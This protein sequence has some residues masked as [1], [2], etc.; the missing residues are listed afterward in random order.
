MRFRCL[1]VM[2]ARFGGLE[3]EGGRQRERLRWRVAF[4]HTGDVA[5]ARKRPR[6]RGRVSDPSRVGL[7]GNCRLQ[8]GRKAQ[9]WPFASMAAH[10]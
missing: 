4:W 7:A 3:P 2:R 10:R 6:A 5:R 9:D 1:A 8:G